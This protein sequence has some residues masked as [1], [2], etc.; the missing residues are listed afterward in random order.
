MLPTLGWE[1][2]DPLWPRIDQQ[3]HYFLNEH[4]AATIFRD[5]LNSGGSKASRTALIC[6]R[7]GCVSHP[8]LRAAH[9]GNTNTSC[10]RKLLCAPRISA[11]GR[12]VFVPL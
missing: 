3:S 2:R 4:R 1:E 12:H 8:Q 7:K 6:A 10:F 5:E 11:T 9:R